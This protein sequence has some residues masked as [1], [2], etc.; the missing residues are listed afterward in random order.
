M[1]FW[2]M[3]CWL[4]G[5]DMEAWVGKQAQMGYEGVMQYMSEGKRWGWID[6]LQ[7]RLSAL[8]YLYRGGD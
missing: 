3:L 5:V 8:C 2:Y 4:Y 7:V 6:T 1:L